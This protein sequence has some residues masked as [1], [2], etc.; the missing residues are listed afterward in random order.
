MCIDCQ[1][2]NNITVKYRYL[3][4]KFNDMLDELLESCKFFNIDLK[5]RYHQ[6]RMKERDE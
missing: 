1:I 4:C 6:L 5:I 3:I 2:I